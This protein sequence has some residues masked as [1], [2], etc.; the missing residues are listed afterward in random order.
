[1]LRLRKFILLLCLAA[2]LVDQNAQAQALP[3]ANFVVN[4]AVANVVTR[5]AA[6]R[7]FAANDPRI[8]VTLTGMGTVS[9]GLN[10]ASTAVG[11]SMAVAGAPVWMGIAAGLGVI[12]LGMGINAMIN[13]KPAQ[14][15]IASTANGNKLKVDAPGDQAPVYVPVQIA[16]Q[17]PRWAQAVASGAPIYR[18][19]GNCY[20][21]E[22]CFALPLLPDVPSYRYNADYQGK[23]VLMTTDLYAFGQWYTFLTKP[24]V[25]MPPGVTVTWMFQG[26]QL[27][28]NSAGGKQITVV[29]YEARSGGDEM[30][31]PSYSR[32]N[33]WNN[34]GTV[35]GDIGPNYYDDL[36]AAAVAMPQSV[37]DAKM[38]AD[39]LARMVDA[40][41][42][43]AAAQPGYQ[44]LPYSLS[45][46]VTATDVQPWINE[47]P[48][49]V[50]T[51]GDLMTPAS[52]PGTQTVPIS[53]TV[54]PTSPGIDPGT[55]PSTSGNV[56]VVN[57][58]NVNVVNTPN[59][60]VVNRV[61]VD[62]GE[63][64]T[65]AL[66]ELET[67]PT[68]RSILE[69]LLNLMPDL[70]AFTTPQ[71]QGECPRP[72]V[73]VLSWDL[74]FDAHCQLAEETR[75]VLYQVMMGGWG[76]AAL[77]IILMA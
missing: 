75:A 39:S 66:P 21:N 54:T 15:S 24:T 68:A 7:G 5:V 52:S 28:P 12:A 35:Y 44:G 4:R 61:Q 69:P 63:A 41:W 73:H 67:M 53:P 51:I 19:P 42:R 23:T 32:T 30:G 1:M 26:I 38:S 37:K 64:P 27:V 58:P 59:V 16:D 3:V 9:T 22:T 6:A 36:S 34:V 33:T 49:A 11:V 56:N 43:Q 65:V 46:P 25:E 55:N 45:Q 62:L 20:A 71:H 18:S 2:M 29:I 8:A 50:P 72:S 70:K 57:T 40:Q 31:L 14:V 77:L 60:N 17:T 47:D 76:L 10:V 74:A 48:T 13:G